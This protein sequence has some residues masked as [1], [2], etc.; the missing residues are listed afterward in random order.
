MRF[1]LIVPTALLAFGASQA[2]G[3]SAAWAA[4]SGGQNSSAGAS[5]GGG[6]VTVQAGE[7][8]VTPTT[9]AKNSTKNAPGKSPQVPADSCFLTEASPA[10]QQLL[11][12][13]GATPGYWADWTCTGA[14]MTD[15]IPL[16]WVV[17]KPPTV[18]VNVALLALEAESKLPLAAPTIETAPPSGTTQLVGVPTWL[19]IDPEPWQV[20]TTTAT[21]GVVVVT[22]TAIPAR[23]VWNM[24]DGTQVTC[25]GPG[26][27]Y[28]PST[29]NGATDCSHTWTQPSSGASGGEFLVTATVYW[30]VAWTA[31]GAPGG[32]NFGL[33]AGP[34]K[35]QDVRVTES[36]AINTP[37]TTGT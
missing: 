16:E 27:P 18:A 35:Q 15:P 6:Q 17:A 10:V 9:V 30:Q 28:D 20:Q 21:A 23:V 22:A 29:P 19:W 1:W 24:G 13:G 33:V 25:D 36:Q 7:G 14:P 37:N 12:I 26:T 3:P 11:G 5:V 32:G 8:Q 2:W 31:A 4:D 34:T